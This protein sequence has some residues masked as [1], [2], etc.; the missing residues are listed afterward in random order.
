MAIIL[1]QLFQRIDGDVHSGSNPNH[2]LF[3]LLEAGLLLLRQVGIQHIAPLRAFL[4]IGGVGGRRGGLAASNG[5]QRHE[6]VSES[7]LEESKPR[8]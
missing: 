1:P 6:A 8:H 4:H 7:T 5:N 3:E 2:L